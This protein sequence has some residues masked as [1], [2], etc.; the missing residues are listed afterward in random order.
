MKISK[1]KSKE[2]CKGSGNGRVATLEV[3]C[4]PLRGLLNQK[5]NRD[6]GALPLAITFHAFSVKN[7]TR[8]A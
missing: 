5:W 8:E 2:S 6:P 7:K 4:R 1:Q 3:F